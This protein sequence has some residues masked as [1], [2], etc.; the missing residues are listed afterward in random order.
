MKYHYPTPQELGMKIPIQLI[1]ELFC[2]GFE[3]ALKGYKITETKQLRASYR[4]GYRA[5]KLYL[6]EI[7]RQ[8][9]ILEFPL[10]GK[11]TIK[12]A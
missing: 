11:I 8:Q 9:G 2:K 4:A 7:R 6:K 5:G 10:V 12:A 1:S 3:H